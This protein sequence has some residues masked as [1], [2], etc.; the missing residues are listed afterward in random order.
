[1]ISMKERTRGIDELHLAQTSRARNQNID[2]N[3]IKTK[4]IEILLF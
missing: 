2:M 4:F 1:M 3:F